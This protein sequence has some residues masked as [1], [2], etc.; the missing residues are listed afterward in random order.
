MTIISDVLRSKLSW[1]NSRGQCYDGASNMADKFNGV[2]NEVKECEPRAVFVHCF[3]HTL[4]LV[5]QDAIKDD[6]LFRNMFCEIQN[7]VVF[8][9]DSPKRIVKLAE[10]QLPEALGLRPLCQTRW[11][12]R[13]SCLDSLLQN[14]TA[15]IDLLHEI[16]CENKTEAGA[17][18]LGLLTCLNKFSLLLIL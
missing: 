18:V 8:V 15:V 6:T 4:N 10:L 3:T 14:Y 2:Q 13:R 9:R 17:K 16:S 7:L 5:V 11:V 12:M 1:S